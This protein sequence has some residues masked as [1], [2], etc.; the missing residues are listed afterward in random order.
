M[1]FKI[2]KKGVITAVAKILA[3]VTLQRIVEEFESSLIN[4]E[5]TFASVNKKCI[6]NVLSSRCNPKKLIAIFRGTYNGAKYH[7]LHQDKS[8]VCKGCGLKRIP[9]LLVIGA[10]CCLGC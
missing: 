9:F 4:F 6:W 8:G 5:E 1:I 10:S 7:V 3:K 2:W